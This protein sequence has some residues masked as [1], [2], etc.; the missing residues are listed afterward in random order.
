MQEY[1]HATQDD[2]VLPSATLTAE[3]VMMGLRLTT[4]IDAG[5]FTRRISKR[6]ADVF[7]PA[8][9]EALVAAGYLDWRDDGFAATPAGRQRLNAVVDALLN[10]QQA[11][12]APGLVR[13]GP[14]L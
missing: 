14:N 12:T 7:A 5:E 11:Q 8:T 10:S 3:L 2:A 6:P 9:I 13:D 1:G 4:G